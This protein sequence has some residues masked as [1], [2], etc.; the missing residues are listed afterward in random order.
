MKD[1]EIIARASELLSTFSYE[2]RE[3]RYDRLFD[4]L[5]DVLPYKDAAIFLL[6]DQRKR[7]E[8]EASRGQPVDLVRLVEFELG[9]GFSAWVAGE[10]R[11]VLLN[12]LQ[13]RQAGAM[14]SFL[15]VPLMVGDEL[16]GVMNFGHSERDAFNLQQAGRAQAVASLLAGILAKHLLISKLQRRNEKI[17]RMNAELQETQARLLAAEKRAAVSATVVSLNHEINN[18]LQ[19]ISGNLQLA[20][21]E[22]LPQE[23][24]EKL[25]IVDGQLRRV[26]KVLKKL[27]EIESPKLREYIDGDDEKMLEVGE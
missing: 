20:L 2:Q 27:R 14:R 1:I 11:I 17:Q 24:R 16:V 18:P 25:E 10:R 21:V 12:D 8:L 7:I 19:I 23:A 9:K 6:D 22:E 5:Q 4:L 3:E 26:A 15:S 13:G